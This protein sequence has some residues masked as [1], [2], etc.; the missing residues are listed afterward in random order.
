MEG[1]CVVNHNE[2][3]GVIKNA[4]LWSYYSGAMVVGHIYEDK[5][6]RFEDGKLI[7][8]SNIEH[9]SD[10]NLIITTKNSVYKVEWRDDPSFE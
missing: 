4:V 8:T 9:F 2:I 7:H 3:D 1:G 5:K 10:D 6:R